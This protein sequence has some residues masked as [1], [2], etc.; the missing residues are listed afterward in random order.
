M[1]LL[2]NNSYVLNLAPNG[3]IPT[4]SMTPHVPTTPLEVVSDIKLCMKE[5]GVTYIHLHARDSGEVNSNNPDIYR[6]F[7]EAVK[8]SFPD[9]PICVSCSGRLDPSFEARSKV[10][11]ITGDLKPD[12]ASLTLSSLN[13][14]KK[15]SINEPSVIIKLAENMADRGIKPELEIFDIGMMNFAQYLIKKGI[16]KPPYYFN[17]ILG[18][19][20][21]AQTKAAHLAAIL[22]EIPSESIWSLGGI[23]SSQ[24]SASL[25]ALSQGGGVR[26]GIEDNIWFDNDRKKLITNAQLVSRIHQIANLTD[27]TMVEPKEF[28]SLLR[29]K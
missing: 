29:I 22:Q 3:V 11:N 18:N 20:F 17:I 1:S 27:L 14:S 2:K 13:F 25:L 5:G 26:T 4:K 12:M 8:N 16:L 19:L 9:L 21:S 28:S 7:I 6:K 24:S 10:L 23:G 15:A